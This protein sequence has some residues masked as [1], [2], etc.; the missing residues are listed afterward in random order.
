[1]L[2]SEYG[3]ASGVASGSAST[4]A[5]GV[6]SSVGVGS[7]GTEGSAYSEVVAQLSDN[8]H[9]CVLMHFP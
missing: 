8:T 6:G 1:M 7:S 9:F 5:S 4:V 3:S 2:S